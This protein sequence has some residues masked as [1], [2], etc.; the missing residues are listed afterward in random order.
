VADREFISVNGARLALI[1]FGGAGPPALLIHGL[2]GRA[3]EWRSTAEW[4][5]ET[6]SVFAFDQR[7]HGDSDKH[8][9]DLT[10]DAQVNDVIAVIEALDRG[11]VLLM[12]QSMGGVTAFL[13]AA[14]HPDLVNHLI[15]IEAHSH[16]DSSDDVGP[17]IARWPIPFQSL[18]TAK[19][20]FRSQGVNA[21][22]WVDALKRSDDG[23]WPEFSL[24]DMAAASADIVAAYDHRPAWAS[25]KCPTLLVGGAKSWLDQAPM[26][27][28]ASSLPGCV[29]ICVEGAGHDVHLDANAGLRQ[30]VQRFIRPVN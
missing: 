6:H 11:P 2:Y 30:A 20:F 24:E 3:T 17:W 15:V 18:D 7:G 26:R 12:G 10:R 8:S 13:A 25:L 5:S 22:V 14:R 1:A 21:D 19:A 16:K 28:M 29:Y 9:S 23:Y 4:L 27:Q